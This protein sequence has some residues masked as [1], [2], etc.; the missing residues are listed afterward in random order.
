ME[1]INRVGKLLLKYSFE[2]TAIHNTV[3]R[4]MKLIREESLRLLPSGKV[5]SEGLQSTLVSSTSSNDWSLVGREEL[6]KQLL[7]ASIDLKT[8]IKGHLGYISS[9]SLNFI[10][11][12]ELI[13]TVGYSKSVFNFLKVI[14]VPT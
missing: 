12:D 7:T 10:H 5:E 8:D 3:L 13:L 1:V 4:F 14:P 11:S 2:E 6:C 9:S